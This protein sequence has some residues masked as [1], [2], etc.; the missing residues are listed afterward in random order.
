MART[1]AMTCSGLDPGREPA[2]AGSPARVSIPAWVRCCW[3]ALLGCDAVL[4]WAWIEAARLFGRPVIYLYL[5]GPVLFGATLLL[6][7]W[8]HTRGPGAGSWFPAGSPGEPANR[9]QPTPAGR[10]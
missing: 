4:I 5:A 1:E 7:G 8:W 9:D 3:W 10:G 2:P 6:I